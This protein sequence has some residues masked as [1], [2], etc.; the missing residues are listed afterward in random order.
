MN[1][2]LPSVGRQCIFALFRRLVFLTSW[3]NWR[4]VVKLE[5]DEL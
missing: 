1:F 2:T 4:Y 5:N 3:Y